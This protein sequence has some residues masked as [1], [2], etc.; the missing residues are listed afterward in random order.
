[1]DGIF[2][3]NFLVLLLRGGESWRCGDSDDVIAAAAIVALWGGLGAA[4][5]GF[6]DVELSLSFG[7]GIVVV[8]GGG[9]GGGDLTFCVGCFATWL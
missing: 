1:M 4:H 6:W 5:G 8:A 2:F 3:L 9:G 7:E